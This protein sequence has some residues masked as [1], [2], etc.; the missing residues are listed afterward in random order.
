MG[1]PDRAGEG[2]LLLVG[3]VSAPHARPLTCLLAFM[4]HPPAG[5]GGARA[6]VGGGALPSKFPPIDTPLHSSLF[7]GFYYKTKLIFKQDL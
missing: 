7:D 3:P 4:P 6:V 2:G 1:V 5:A